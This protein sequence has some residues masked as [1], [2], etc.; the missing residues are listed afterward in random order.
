MDFHGMLGYRDLIL[1][2]VARELKVRYRRSA[3]GFVWTMLH[4]VLMTLV[5]HFVFGS[6]FRAELARYPVY[7][8]VGILFWNFFSQTLVASMNSL[9][10]NAPLLQKLPLPGAIFPLATL[11]AGVVNLVLAL[12][13]LI[14]VLMFLQPSPGFA[15]LFV[16]V[17][18][19]LLAVFTLGVGLLLAPLAVFFTDVIEMTGMVL[20][21][22]L[23]LTPTFYPVS[24]LPGRAGLLVRSNPL[25]WLLEAFREPICQ[26]RL[27]SGT[28]LA[29]CVGAALASLLIGALAFRRSAARI[30]YSA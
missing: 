1:A 6:L 8:L 11:L 2:L 19:V 13:P 10:G 22:V 25:Y 24:I 29:G 20:G 14:V 30:P 7:V 12:V 3:L 16:P 4:P 23:Y 21:L 27:A 9:R 26:G 18:I 5:L 28:Q 15:L 17:A